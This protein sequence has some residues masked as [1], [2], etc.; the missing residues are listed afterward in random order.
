MYKEHDRRSIRRKQ[1]GEEKQL[2]RNHT[3]PPE[4]AAQPIDTRD[5]ETHVA[6]ED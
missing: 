1:A 2:P 6:Q 5:V 4:E 3:K